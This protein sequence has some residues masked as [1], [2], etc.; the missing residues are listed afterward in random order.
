MEQKN[1]KRK[2]I[3]MI[4]IL[5]ALVI[6][7][8]LAIGFFGKI[9]NKM[10]IP[11]GNIDIFDIIFSNNQYE[12]NSNS[13]NETAE[14]NEGEYIVGKTEGKTTNSNNNSNNSSSNNSSNNNNNTPDKV[15]EEEKGI[16]VSDGNTEFLESTPLNIFTHTSYHISEDKIAP[17]SENTYQFVIRNNNKFGISYDLNLIES[18]NYDINM[19]YRLK[20]N[21]NYVVGSDDKWVTAEE[22]DQYNIRLADETHDVYTLDWKWFES[23]NDTKI[24]TSIDAD[25]G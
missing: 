18:N 2:I 8:F 21:G 16:T 15:V 13:G 5:L 23:E 10:R 17:M 7:I 25:Y 3:L 24:G 4:L 9:E 11:T 12:G 14:S 1:E 6:L 22:L 19:K 20:L